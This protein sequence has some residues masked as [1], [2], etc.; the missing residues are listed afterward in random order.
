[1]EVNLLVKFIKHNQNIN[2]H[3]RYSGGRL[4]EKA[5][6]HQRPNLA[7]AAEGPV[8]EFWI[9]DDTVI[10]TAVIRG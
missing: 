9:E 6:A 3:K 2:S 10:A 7:G 8:F 4:P 1:M 5:N